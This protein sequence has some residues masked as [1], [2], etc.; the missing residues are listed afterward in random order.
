MPKYAYRLEVFD[1]EW[2]RVHGMQTATLPSLRKHLTGR[3]VGPIARIVRTDG[4]VME[5]HA[6]VVPAP[7]V[8]FAPAQAS[9]VVA[10]VTG[11]RAFHASKA[12][13]YALR[14]AL[15]WHGVTLLLHGDCKHTCALTGCTRMSLDQWAGEVAKRLD[16]EVEAV[17]Y[18]GHLGK[19]GGP[20]RNRAM[21]ER[22]S[23]LIA[24]P[25]GAG[26]ADCTEQA[27]ERGLTIVRI[28]DRVS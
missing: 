19:A 6:A 5:E 28:V 2:R 27:R 18:F 1:G 10:V 4:E 26:T 22:A 7:M 21:V 20:A 8:E 11:G 25:G 14:T 12:D 15:R 9:P 24:F 17:P 13:A 23:V 16:I 3:R